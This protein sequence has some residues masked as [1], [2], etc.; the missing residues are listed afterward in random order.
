V[1][2]LSLTGIVKDYHGLRPLR[3]NQL[4]VDAGEQV[5]LVGVDEPVAET[6]VNLVTGASIPDSGEVQVFGQSTAS[7]PDEAAWL[8]AIDRFAIV[9]HR[10]VLLE[11]LTVVQ[12]LALSFSLDIEPPPDEIRRQ[13]EA[14]ATE[15]GLQ[16]GDWER[17]LVDLGDE[18]K[19]RVRLGRALAFNPAIAVL[20]HP[21][22]AIPRPDVRRIGHDLRAIFERRRLAALT[23]TADSEFAGAV[24]SRVLTLEPAT[25]R[26]RGQRHRW[27]KSY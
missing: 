24:A 11:A 10:A 27:F 8:A 18:T 20:E 3:I 22:R 5:A 6:L 19:L 2:V 26:I 13:A 16:A 21:T 1:T 14:I 15:V 12:N 9:S 7:I 23:L 4:T 25:G 17:R